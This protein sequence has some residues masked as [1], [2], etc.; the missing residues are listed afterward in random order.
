VV[1]KI[2]LGTLLVGLIGVLVVGAVIRTQ[3][4]TSSNNESREGSGNQNR[5]GQVNAADWITLNATV[6]AVDETALT[7]ALDGG[8][9]LVVQSRAWTYAQSQG[10]AA[11]AGDRL[12]VSGFYDEAGQ[13]EAGR[14]ENRATQ[15]MIWLRDDSGRPMWAGRG[16]GG[17]G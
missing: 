9:E 3:D 11:R 5:G 16:Q 1:K 12:I 17:S 13:L 14:I 2:I 10:L 15:Q 4:K 7:L 8:G 6:Q